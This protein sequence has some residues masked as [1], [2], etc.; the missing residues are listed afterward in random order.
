MNRNRHIEI[1]RIL[2][3]NE[4]Y[5]SAHSIAKQLHVSV[6]TIYND[7]ESSDFKRL[8]HGASLD[9]KT[10]AG[11]RLNGSKQQI[12]RVLFEFEDNQKNTFSHGN[13]DDVHE[14]LLLLL[15]QAT[16]LSI[17]DLASLLYKSKNSIVAILNQA[18]G[19]VTRKDCQLTRKP[20]YGVKLCG[21]ERKLRKLFVGLIQE[22]IKQED[23]KTTTVLE[24]IFDPNY[25]KVI[26]ESI[27]LSEQLMNTRYTDHDFQLLLIKLCVIAKRVHI[28]LSSELPHSF[29]NTMQEYYIAAIVKMRIEENLGITLNRQDQ[30]EIAESILSTRKTENQQ[31]IKQPFDEKVIDNFIAKISSHLDISL[32]ESDE[33]KVNLIN[34]LR[35]AIRRIKNG[36]LSENPLLEHIR[37]KFTHIYIA[38]MIT[39]DEIESQENI[40]FDA[41][42][43]G[44]ICLHIVA[45]INRKSKKK[46]IR[47]LLVS[48][49]GLTIK[50]Y[51]K[52]S[53]EKLFTEISIVKIIDNESKDNLDDYDLILNSTQNHLL[54]E[55]II[56]IKSM[57]EENDLAEIRHWLY[58][59]EIEKA[60]DKKD[61][62]KDHLFIFHDE[63]TDKHRLL[64]KYCGYLVET[65]FVKDGFYDSVIERENK[66]TTS[67]GRGVAVPH[68]SLNMVLKSVILI[69][70]T[71]KK[72]IWDELS[73]DLIFLTALDT[74]H[75]ADYNFFFKRLFHI[76]EDESQLEILR[77][78]NNIEDVEELLLPQNSKVDAHKNND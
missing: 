2:I 3:N 47:T 58:Y 73:V 53:I 75:T 27:Q 77:N 70:H 61:K 67:I 64:K 35:P 10:N 19:Y 9:K 37:Y 16:P 43:I 54:G 18:E 23:A 76:I 46:V 60:M 4:E 30:C 7:L 29:D 42:E 71:K 48:N 11:I 72:I 45:A 17:D 6:R 25:V 38:V 59:R 41:N 8:L 20:N 40:Y 55:K 28:G 69:I 49:E 57:I 15:L 12:E 78:S 50:E 33:L 13:F 56:N 32:Q 21:D 65:G 5:S 1:L 52:S 66:S 44:F 26:F 51:I 36:T 68:G 62:L 63:E 39:I 31:S 14:L 24:T 74:L 34:H 22:Q